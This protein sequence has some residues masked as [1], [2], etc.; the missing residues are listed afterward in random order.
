MLAFAS[1]WQTMFTNPGIL[2]KGYKNIDEEKLTLK[3][4][5]LLAERE[6]LLIG[7]KIRK[8]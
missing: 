2:P 1:H 5:K 6:A 4:A 8:L 3:F 7:P